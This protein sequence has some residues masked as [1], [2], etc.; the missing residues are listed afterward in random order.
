MRVKIIFFSS[1]EHVLVSRLLRAETMFRTGGS[2]AIRFVF[3]CFRVLSFSSVFRSIFVCFRYVFVVSGV[4]RAETVFR[5]GGQ[6]G[7]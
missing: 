1:S 5:T 6:C 3:V 2:V 7:H 4:L